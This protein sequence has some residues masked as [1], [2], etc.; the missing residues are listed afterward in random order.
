MDAD[1]DEALDMCSSRKAMASNWGLP[2]VGALPSWLP[3]MEA[4]ASRSL[5]FD[6][7]SEATLSQRKV[8]AL[9]PLRSIGTS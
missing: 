8:K 4:A 2:F 1:E 7:C 9:P 3:V 5:D 6:V